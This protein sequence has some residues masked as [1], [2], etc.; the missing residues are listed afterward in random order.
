MRTRKRNETEEEWLENQPNKDTE[1]GEAT[2]EGER[3]QSGEKFPE[4]FLIHLKAA[5]KCQ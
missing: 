2:A 5:Q 3:T 1:E 4:L